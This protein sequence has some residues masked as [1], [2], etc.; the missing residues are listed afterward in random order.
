MKIYFQ[1]TDGIHHLSSFI[2]L[3]DNHQLNEQEIEVMKQ[4]IFDAHV[5]RIKS[6]ASNRL[7][8]HLAN[9]NVPAR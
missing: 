7:Q 2:E 8:A 4:Q 9:L 5:K 6:I 3:A 1:K